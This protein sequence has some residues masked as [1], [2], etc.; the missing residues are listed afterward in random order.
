M[1]QFQRRRAAD[2][3]LFAAHSVDHQHGLVG[4]LPQVR[5]SFKG[6]IYTPSRPLSVTMN[7]AFDQGLLVRYLRQ[8]DPADVT[9][10]QGQRRHQ[11]AGGI[12]EGGGSPVPV[13]YL[14]LKTY[15]CPGQ[16]TCAPS[17]PVRLTSKVLVSGYIQR[18]VSV[19]SWSA[20][21]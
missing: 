15:V 13:N 7:N 19:L 18:T 16:S 9:R 17:G 11:I 14:V 3:R 4:E 20:Q 5:A 6:T 1:R 21:R 12:P 10:R 8:I 2:R